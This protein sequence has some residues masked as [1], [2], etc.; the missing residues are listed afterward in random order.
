MRNVA[1]EACV[2]L[3]FLALALLGGPWFVASALACGVAIAS[4]A[5]SPR[6]GGLP[7]V[8]FLVV[9][10]V[11]LA[12]G[13]AGGLLSLEGA[14]IGGLV[15]LQLQRRL[16]RQS[17]TDDRVSVVVAG[18]MLVVTAGRTTDIGFL[19]LAMAWSLVMPLALLPGG[20]RTAPGPAHL[21]AGGAVHLVAS[22]AFFVLL[23]RSGATADVEG[24]TKLVGFAPD[25][26]LGALD[27]LLDDPTVVFRA[28]VEG[29][30][31]PERTYWRGLALDG[32]DGRRWYSSTPPVPAETRPGDGLVVSIEPTGPSDGVLFAPGAVQHVE[33]SDL[34]A[35]PQGAWF[36]PAASS[37]EPYVV[38][39]TPASLGDAWF[40]EPRARHDLW[41]ALPALDARVAELADQVA[42]EGD[43]AV[44]A[45]RLRAWLASEVTYTRQGGDHGPRPLSHFL[46]ERREGH[47]E[48]VAAGLT[49]LLRS[50]GIPARIVNGFLGGEP[51]P[52][53]GDVV[54]RRQHAHSWTEAL[55]DGRWVLL[56][57]TPAAQ[58]V[59]APPAVRWS[60]AAQSAW[61]GAVVGYDREAQRAR[62]ERSLT[63][64]RGWLGRPLRAGVLGLAV[65]L[66]LMGAV[67]AV[68]RVWV[69]RLPGAAVRARDGLAA[70]L[71]RAEQALRDAG[72]V[73]PPAAPPVEVA[74]WLRGRAPDEAVDAFEA[75]AWLHYDVLFGGVSASTSRGRARDLADR[76]VAAVDPTASTDDGTR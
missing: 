39:V 50:E 73:P 51:D 62:L 23:P 57:A 52:L 3:G 30:E 72:L 4:R 5:L 7:G 60:D 47:C 27:A 61:E 9:G 49:V 67:V 6:F 19:L 16:T 59:A 71:H 25:V 15:L 68:R 75:L 33:A 17:A 69:R 1:V 38:T 29:G 20:R 21:V 74:R 54:V 44:R 34:R 37:S 42:G 41:L 48:Y 36:V 31:L 26:E 11:V 58:V 12:S 64:M 40:S 45:E 53:A 13:G 35:D 65:V 18:L 10:S 46:L 8:L 70:P 28:R 2:A 32:F 22:L 43:P 56:D 14:V 24:T 76:V 66:G 55:I 63:W